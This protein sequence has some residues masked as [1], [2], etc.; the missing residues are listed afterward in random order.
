MKKIINQMY[1]RTVS[2]NVWWTS[3][4]QRIS[5]FS[6]S[7]N[8]YLLNF[9]KTIPLKITNLKITYPKITDLKTANLKIANLKLTD[10]K[11]TNLKVITPISSPVFKKLLQ[12][13]TVAGAFLVVGIFVNQPLRD[14][15]LQALHWSDESQDIQAADEFNQ[16]HAPSMRPVMFGLTGKAPNKSNLMESSVMYSPVPSIANLA[17]QIIGRID[18]QA[19]D[20]RLLDSVENQYKVANLMAE[21]YKVDVNKLRTFISHA[22]V[23]GREVNLDPML[24]V[25][26]MAIESNFN[27]VA[28]SPAG[29]QG[30]MQVMTSIHAD[31]FLPYGGIGAAFK[32]EAN[33]RVGAYILKY[34]IA[35]AGNLHVGLRYYVGGAYIGDGGYAGK[36][37]RERD[38][39][40]SQLNSMGMGTS[41]DLGSGYT[42]DID[43]KEVNKSPIGRGQAIK[44][45]ESSKLL[46]ADLTDS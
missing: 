46:S 5:K 9:L 37:I 42:N 25:A 21:K 19:Q 4:T 35:Q 7:L 33:I 12:G 26:V 45:S 15:V 2:Q 6:T 18:P 44:P 31:K 41:V 8:N 39:L 10:L 23:V 1:Q 20:L 24:L 22:V 43:M 13:C 27:P 3:C 11:L 32:P 30:L 14:D 36:V 17:N 38:F 40:I 34:F 28:Q 29:A 16:A